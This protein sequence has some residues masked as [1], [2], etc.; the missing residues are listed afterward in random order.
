MKA[1]TSI[2]Q[3]MSVFNYKKGPKCDFL[4]HY[5]ITMIQAGGFNYA[6]P[7][8]FY[9]KKNKNGRLHRKKK[10]KNYRRDK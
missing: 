5:I 7:N 8:W 2:S 1:L 4:M 6:L 10:K 9:Q 3:N